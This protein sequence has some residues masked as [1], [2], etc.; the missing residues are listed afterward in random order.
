[1]LKKIILG[2]INMI[3]FI[4]VEEED[5]I[6]VDSWKGVESLSLVFHITADSLNSFQSELGQRHEY[7]FLGKK[8]KTNVNFNTTLFTKWYDC[9][10][11]PEHNSTKCHDCT[12]WF[13]LKLNLYCMNL[14]YPPNCLLVRSILYLLCFVQL[15]LSNLLPQDKIFSTMVRVHN[16]F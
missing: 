5:Q 4:L 10:I 3:A 16:L 7:E 6:I 11:F 15:S 13:V 8:R 14:V 2:N 1:M 9:S 12:I